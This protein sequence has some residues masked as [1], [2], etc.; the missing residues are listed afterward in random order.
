MSSTPLRS[1]SWP[2]CEP[3]R[4]LR[5]RVDARSIRAP[6][7]FA[8]ATR[9][10]SPNAWALAS[11]AN[12]LV[13]EMRR[14]LATS[15]IDG[16]R[17][18]SGHPR[19][20]P[21]VPEPA[22]SRRSDR[23]PARMLFRHQDAKVL[24][25]SATPYKMFT[26]RHRGRRGPPRGL[27]Q[28]A[29]LPPGPR[30]GGR[31]AVRSCSVRWQGF[32]ELPDSRDDVLTAQTRARATS[33]ARVI[34]RTE[35]LA[36]SGDR[37]G[38]V[39]RR[40][41]DGLRSNRRRPLLRRARP[42]RARDR[43][44][45]HRRVL[46]VLAVPTQLH[47]RLRFDQD[48][49][50]A[51]RKREGPVASRR[52]GCRASRDFGEIDLGNARL[53]GLAADTV[54]AGLE[55]ALAAAVAAVLPG[56]RPVRPVRP[57]RHRYQAPRLL[58]LERRPE[59][60]LLLSSYEAERRMVGLGEDPRRNTAEDR[61]AMSQPLR[62]AKNSDRTAAGTMTTFALMVPSVALARLVDP[63]RS[64]RER[65]A[66]PNRPGSTAEVRSGC[67]VRPPRVAARRRDSGRRGRRLVAAVPLLLEAERVGVD[68]LIEWLRATR[69][70]RS[71][72][73]GVRTR[74]R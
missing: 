29:R 39:V 70:S 26:R 32:R 60:D 68:T 12:R 53:R 56:R 28:H 58:R 2:R 16:A 40:T 69:S 59:G 30:R 51:A 4:P 50:K 8:H 10:D 17:T 5:R 44:P 54:D 66:S 25:L 37:N 64:L 19:R 73:P 47:G 6:R 36:V 9:S 43:P 46:E 67:A 3:T 18:R 11:E 74:S 27:P 42:G 61:K 48:F 7:R 41:L 20:V 31:F 52:A 15:C 45:R 34:A 22:V 49:E 65:T 71:S 1:D 33:C 35:R 63:L 21:A 57:A 62:I 38:M 55:A 24:L 13:G 14:R 72:R 23:R